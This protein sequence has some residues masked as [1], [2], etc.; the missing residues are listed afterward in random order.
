MPLIP[1]KSSTEK[2]ATNFSEVLGKIGSSGGSLFQ[3]AGEGALPG[4]FTKSP[5][6][7]V[8]K[9]ETSQTPGESLSKN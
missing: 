9:E 4:L 2:Q 7:P 1:P 5:Q 3:K 6:L 8:K